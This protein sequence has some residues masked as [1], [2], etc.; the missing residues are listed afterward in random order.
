MIAYITP[1]Y[2]LQSLGNTI[3]LDRGAC[4]HAQSLSCVWLFVTPWTVAHQ[5][6]LSKGFSRQESWSWLPCPPPGDL[7][8]LGIEPKPLMSPVMAGQFFYHWHH[9]KLSW[10]WVSTNNFRFKG[11]Q[12]ERSPVRESI[13]EGP[14]F[15]LRCSNRT[16]WESHLVGHW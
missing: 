14:A 9:L 6:P 1:F 11:L 15:H 8:S 4:L 2:L 5:A 3:L 10:I 13:P 7:P 16:D 12:S